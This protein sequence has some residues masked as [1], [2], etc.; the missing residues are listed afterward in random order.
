MGG[1]SVCFWFSEGAGPPLLVLGPP[2][3]LRQGSGFC[4]QMACAGGAHSHP[5]ILR[6]HDDSTGKVGW[7]DA[8]VRGPLR[9]TGQLEPRITRR[10]RCA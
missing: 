10:E 9:G 6:L 4:T 8:R 1:G 7:V 5:G 3:L 2:W